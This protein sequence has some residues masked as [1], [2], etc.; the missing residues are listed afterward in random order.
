MKLEREIEL[1]ECKG[2]KRVCEYL[3]YYECLLD[4]GSRLLGKIPALRLSYL[5]P[6]IACYPLCFVA[7]Q[8]R[9]Q[10][11]V[12]IS[13][14]SR[15]IARREPVLIVTTEGVQLSCASAA[16]ESHFLFTSDGV[17]IF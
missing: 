9:Q 10:Y 13:R 2:G 16:N 1:E 4:L 6:G 14:G 3:R 5:R 12:D 17:L 11:G 7:H 8:R 15:H